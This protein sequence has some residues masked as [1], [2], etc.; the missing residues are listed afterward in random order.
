MKSQVT[1]R[2]TLKLA[3]LIFA[4]R[5]CR[6]AQRDESHGFSFAAAMEWRRAAELSCWIT[7]LANR[8][9]REWERIMQLP[10]RLAA[11]M[12]VADVVPI[13][14]FSAEFALTSGNGTAIVGPAPINAP[15]RRVTPIAHRG[16]HKEPVRFNRIRRP[17]PGKGDDSED[18]QVDRCCVRCNS[19]LLVA[20]LLML[21]SSFHSRAA[22]PPLALQRAVNPG[23]DVSDRELTIRCRELV[24]EL[25]NHPYGR[26]LVRQ[27]ESDNRRFGREQSSQSTGA[28]RT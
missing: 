2:H 8:Y 10:C 12:G 17:K 23:L 18:S 21:A 9:W 27:E 20:V 24:H 4:L 5:Y 3:G 1:M 25:N 19:P 11:P 6:V 16:G 15:N 26:R 22:E 14:V 7:P 13:S 28:K